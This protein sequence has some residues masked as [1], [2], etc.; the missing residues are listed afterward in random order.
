MGFVRSFTAAQNVLFL[1]L[2]FT[3]QHLSA[4]FVS[5]MVQR[6]QLTRT[7]GGVANHRDWERERG[8]G[9][10]DDRERERSD[11]RGRR[12]DRPTHVKGSEGTSLYV[13]NLR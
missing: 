7:C 2:L 5:L 13:A 10:R 4:C 1:Y 9:D 12:G 11:S 8:R 3:A 6:S